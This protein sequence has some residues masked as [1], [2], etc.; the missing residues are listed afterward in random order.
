MLLLKAHALNESK[1]CADHVVCGAVQGVIFRLVVIAQGDEIAIG[2]RAVVG[3]VAHVVKMDVSLCPAG[4]ADFAEFLVE[5]Y[6]SSEPKFRVYV[7][8]VSEC[9][10]TRLNFWFWAPPLFVLPLV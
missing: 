8:M 2:L 7:L 4:S 5:G 6:S 10:L 1:G 3:R 9:I